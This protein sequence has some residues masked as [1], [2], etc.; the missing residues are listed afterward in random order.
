LK[1]RPLLGV[2]LGLFLPV[3]L[4]V[5]LYLG[6]QRTAP[7]LLPAQQHQTVPMLAPEQ[8]RAL[9][10]Y[11]TPCR[12]PKDCEPPLACFFNQRSSEQ[13]CTD[14][15]CEA[16]HECPEGGVC[17]RVYTGDG[18]APVR[19]C[20]LAGERQEGEE[21]KA[22]PRFAEEGCAR[23]LLCEGW[24][25]RPCQVDDAASCPEGFFCDEGLNGPSC[26]P[27]CEGRACPEGQRCVQLGERVSVCAVVHGQDCL[28]SPCAAKSR[29][30]VTSSWRRPGEIWMEC[31]KFCGR[32]PSVCA[33]GSVCYIY[34]CYQRCDPKQPEACGPHKH[35]RQHIPEAPWLCLPDLR[36]APPPSSP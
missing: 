17:R 16:D 27:T 20:V 12:E 15:T 1:W 23:G 2:A 13:Y 9:A 11:E 3:P 35:C 29:C 36:H 14:S 30:D 4:A 32:D 7:A 34:E 19:A 10:T 31:R 18:Q 33:E 21:C 26:L 8:R 28:A 5:L 22:M 6:M 25:G 24:C